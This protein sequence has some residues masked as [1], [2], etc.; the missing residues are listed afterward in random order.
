[1]VQHKKTEKNLCLNGYNYR[2][3]MTRLTLENENVDYIYESNRKEHDFHSSLTSSALFHKGLHIS[4]IRQ[5][6][7]LPILWKKKKGKNSDEH[8]KL[9]H[10]DLS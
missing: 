2:E 4:T 6:R 9:K 10:K 8:L 5:V 7:C 1:M 3:I